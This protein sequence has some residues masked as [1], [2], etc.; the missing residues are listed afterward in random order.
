MKGSGVVKVRA[1]PAGVGVKSIGF[2]EIPSRNRTEEDT[3]V[4]IVTPSGV[5]GDG[6]VYVISYGQFTGGNAK[7]PWNIIVEVGPYRDIAFSS[8][9]VFIGSSF[10]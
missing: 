3:G 4:R 2:G 1:Y 7:I 8:L 10:R 9:V 5:R 6:A